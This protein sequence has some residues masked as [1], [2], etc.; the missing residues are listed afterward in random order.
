[1]ELKC[2]LCSA[3]LVGAVFVADCGRAV[4]IA[5]LAEK[6]KTCCFAKQH[7]KTKE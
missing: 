3:K 2:E 1:M 6:T 5:C 7:A 4:H